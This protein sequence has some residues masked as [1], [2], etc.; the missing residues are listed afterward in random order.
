ML[1]C[2]SECGFQVLQICLRYFIWYN[3]V[4]PWLHTYLLDITRRKWNER[5]SCWKFFR[6]YIFWFLRK[7]YS[8]VDSF[9]MVKMN[10]D[11]PRDN[12]SIESKQRSLSWIWTQNDQTMHM[13]MNIFQE[14][15]KGAFIVVLE[16][17]CTEKQPKGCCGHW[18]KSILRHRCDGLQCREQKQAW[19]AYRYRPWKPRPGKRRISLFQANRWTSQQNI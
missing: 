16:L 10:S 12:W 6:F 13:F 18:R 15:Q 8:H 1:F 19:K 3:M 9:V 7:H 2:R 14:A 11:R 17:S 4:Q 5:Y